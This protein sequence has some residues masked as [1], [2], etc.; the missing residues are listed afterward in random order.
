LNKLGRLIGLIK[1]NPSDIVTV[2][3][4]TLE[5]EE[6]L[7]KTILIIILLK[8]VLDIYLGIIALTIPSFLLI[9]N[10]I[11]KT[12]NKTKNSSISIILFE[13][14]IL[15]PSIN[16]QSFKNNRDSEIKT[17]INRIIYSLVTKHKLNDKTNK[18]QK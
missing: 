5:Q 6:K 16:F 15:P 17:I 18:P 13:L 2:L 8:L 3:L 14:P 7:S 4:I 12:P 11:S 10:I 9:T 1:G